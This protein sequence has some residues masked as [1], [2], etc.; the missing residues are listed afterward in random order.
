MSKRHYRVRNWVQY[1]EALVKRGSL[2]FWFDEETLSQWHKTGI[3]GQRGRPVIYSDMAIICALTLRSLFHLTLRA[4]EGFVASLIMM[5]HLTIHCPDY[6]TLCKRQKSLG[7]ELP[8]RQKKCDEVTDVVFDA[9]G[10]KVYGEGEWKVRQYGYSRRRAWRKLTILL[11]AEHQEIINAVLST[12][13]YNDKELLPELLAGVEEKLGDAIGDGGYDSHAQFGLLS[14]QGANPLIP[15]RQ[16]AKIKR[17]GNNRAA[18]LARD[19]VVR[20]IRLLGRKGWKKSVGY[21]RRSLVETAMFRLKKLF[22]GHLANRE[23][24]HQATEAFIRCRS[25]NLITQMGMPESYAIN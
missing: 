14:A 25:L 9:T 12:N 16:D 8:R 18:P 23:F 11:D 3:S 10:L 17:H 20:Q 5:M 7:I 6:S 19:K 22:G 21:H 24:K 2:N 15:P 13:D 4:T 1:N